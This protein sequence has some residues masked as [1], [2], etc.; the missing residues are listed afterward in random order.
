MEQRLTYPGAVRLL[1]MGPLRV[2]R[3]DV[4]AGAVLRSFQDGG[5]RR[6]RAG[7]CRLADR[8][9]SAGDLR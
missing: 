9:P 1:I 5:P 4:E 6:L 7:P 8:L 2:W 3:G